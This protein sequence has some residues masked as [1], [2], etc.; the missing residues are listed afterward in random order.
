MLQCGTGFPSFK[1]LSN[2]LL[3]TVCIMTLHLL[4]DIWI[5]FW[6]MK[7]AAM[8]MGVQISL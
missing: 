7:N 5:A 2:I 1:M 4:T 8:N 3:I 6:F